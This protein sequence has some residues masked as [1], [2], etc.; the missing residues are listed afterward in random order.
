MSV[1]SIIFVYFSEKWFLSFRSMTSHLSMSHHGPVTKGPIWHI[2][3]SFIWVLLLINL[4][5]YHWFDYIRSIGDLKHNRVIFTIA[6]C[7]HLCLH[8]LIRLV[9]PNPPCI[10]QSNC[11]SPCVW[12]TSATSTCVFPCF[13]Q[14]QIFI[15]SAG[16]YYGT[17]PSGSFSNHSVNPYML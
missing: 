3:F 13:W 12:K 5:E 2:C 15:L 17:K 4:T 6:N 14:K 9:Q 11:N 7:G 8:L 16:V 1:L 10:Q